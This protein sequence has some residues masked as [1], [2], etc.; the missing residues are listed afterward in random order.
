MRKR[1]NLE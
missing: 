1:W